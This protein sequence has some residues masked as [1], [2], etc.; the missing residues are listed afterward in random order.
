MLSL[1]GDRERE[2]R[3][4]R[5]AAETSTWCT[6]FGEGRVRVP[7][8]PFPYDIVL[9]AADL[10]RVVLGACVFGLVGVAGNALEVWGDTLSLCSRQESGS[11]CE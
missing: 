8:L 2:R 4:D 10:G 6:P 7:P 5:T 9:L 11:D 3:K 1:D